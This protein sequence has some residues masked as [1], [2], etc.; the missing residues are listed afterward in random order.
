MYTDRQPRDADSTV[1][2]EERIEEVTTST[3]FSDLDDLDVNDCNDAF[4]CVPNANKSV[5]VAFPELGV[6]L[7]DSSVYCFDSNSFLEDKSVRITD[8]LSWEE[9]WLFQKKR[10]SDCDV[11]AQYCFSTL[12]AADSVNRMLIP[13]PS[14]LL[15]AKVGTKEI[16]E[17]SDL[18]EHNSGISVTFSEDEEN[19]EN[20]FVDEEYLQS[21]EICLIPENGYL[22]DRLSESELSKEEAVQVKAK[23]ATSFNKKA[24]NEAICV[25]V[26]PK[27]VPI[28][29]FVPSQQRLTETV[30]DPCFVFPPGSASVQSG[31]LIQFCC[32][33]K[34]SQPI[35]VSWFRGD[36]RLENDHYYR[37]KHSG[38]DHILEIKSTNVQIAGNYSCVVFN[39]LNQKW[40]DFTLHVKTY[41][42][43]RKEKSLSSSQP[44]YLNKIEKE[45]VRKESP[46]VIQRTWDQRRAEEKSEKR[47]A[48]FESEESVPPPLPDDTVGAS[49]TPTASIA[50][51]EHRKW[52]ECAVKWPNNPYTKENIE[53]RNLLRAVSL[54]SVLDD[55]SLSDECDKMPNLSPSKDLTRYKRDYFVPVVEKDEALN[56]FEEKVHSLTARNLTKFREQSKDVTENPT[57][58]ISRSKSLMDI[59][60]CQ[61]CSSNS[62]ETCSPTNEG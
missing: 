50:E 31:I 48:E 62:S 42:K 17:L 34:G 44:T 32:R 43:S 46:S 6:D 35:G 27:N 37:I 56:C 51:R 38:N 47:Q 21:Y 12:D 24:T 15:Q 55:C 58:V 19:V 57:V 29:Q 39:H 52:E 5:R 36:H 30:D 25:E 3:T 7:V 13:N 10:K 23:S 9:N 61:P 40:S 26:V 22:S 8:L 11:V 2:L 4:E 33:V 41:Q 49:I 53:R 18:S 60:K 59:D 54:D 20:D 28:P 45:V 14:H 1:V 16:D